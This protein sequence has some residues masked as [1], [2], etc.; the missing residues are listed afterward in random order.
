MELTEYEKFWDHMSRSEEVD[1]DDEEINMTLR[2]CGAYW[3]I[4][5]C[6][7]WN[8]AALEA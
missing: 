3:K 2:N 8:A 4:T 6:M 5:G 1:Y 7:F